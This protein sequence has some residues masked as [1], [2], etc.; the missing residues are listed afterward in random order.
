[1]K[2]Q[3]LLPWICVLGL[4]AGAAVLFVSGQKKEAELTR[5]R[6]ESQ[7]VQDLQ[8]KLDEA[9]GQVK[10]KEEELAGLR[11][12]KE[13]LLRLRSEVRK[14]QESGQQLA[15]QAAAAQADAEQAKA[16]IAQTAQAG[17]QQMQQL[18][19]E[20]QQL[21]TVAVQGVRNVQ[22]DTAACINNLRQLD[23]AKQQWALEHNKTAEAVP[24]AL[25]IAPYLNNTLPACPAGGTYTI[26]AV[27][28][29]PTCS[30]PGHELPR[31]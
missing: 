4:T 30:V 28:L 21:R 8:T 14:L 19:T 17:A 15:K 20:N 12:D 31:Q 5:L 3:T 11:K 16:R 10:A 9:Q 27:N 25:D 24:T 1:M 6:Q 22:R 26:N 23:G 18:Q 7:N 29:V 2:V 13:D